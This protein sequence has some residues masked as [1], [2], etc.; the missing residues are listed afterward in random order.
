MPFFWA[1]RSPG[2]GGPQREPPRGVRNPDLVNF[3]SLSLPICKRWLIIPASLDPCVETR[4]VPAGEG[5]PG[6]A[7]HMRSHATPSC[8]RPHTL[9]ADW[10]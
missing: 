9:R 5:G 1:R 6:A 2:S 7:C 8:M 10:P 4:E 3:S